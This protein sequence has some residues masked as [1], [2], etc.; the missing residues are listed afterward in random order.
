MTCLMES[1]YRHERGDKVGSIPSSF[2]FEKTDAINAQQVNRPRLGS[3]MSICLPSKG[4]MNSPGDNNCF[5]NAA[6]QVWRF[7]RLQETI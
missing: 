1:P 6:I 5:L 7:E 2:T 3:R 4:F